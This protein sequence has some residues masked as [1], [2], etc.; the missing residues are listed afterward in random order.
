MKN[1]VK[2]A[3][4]TSVCIMFFLCVFI[5]CSY[6]DTAENNAAITAAMEELKAFFPHGKYWNGGKT[7]DQMIAIA[8]DTSSWS[9]S[10]FGVTGKGCGSTCTSNHY[11][12][13]DSSQCYAFARYLGYLMWPQFGFPGS[14]W[15]R[16]SG[17]D[18][19]S[20]TL[21]PGDIVCCGD[22]QHSA[23]V[24]K[25]S[26]TNAYFANVLGS[27]G[28]QIYW[29]EY[30]CGVSGKVTNMST[31]LQHVKNNGGYILKHPPTGPRLVP[32]PTPNATTLEFRNVVYPKTFKINTSIGWYLSGGTLVSNVNLSSIRSIIKDSNGNTISN[33]EGDTGEISIS[34]ESYAVNSIDSKVK[35]N[36]ITSSGNYTWTLIGKDS[37]GRTLTLVMPF[38]AVTSGTT[39]TSTMSIQYNDAVTATGIILGTTI[40]NFA[41]QT[42]TY[43]GYDENDPTFKLW[44]NFTPANTT[45]CNI[46]WTSSNENVLK[47]S[48][49]NVSEGVCVGTF[50][51]KGLGSTVITAK[52]QDGSNLQA[53]CT[54]KFCLSDINLTPA[55]KQVYINETTAI[56]AA[57]SPSIGKNS[58]LIWTSSNPTIATV[59]SNGVVTGISLGTTT[60]TAKAK[61][62]GTYNEIKDTCTITVISNISNLSAAMWQSP[63]PEDDALWDLPVRS[64]RVGEVF[65]L[66]VYWDNATFSNTSNLEYQF[67][68]DSN[69]GLTKVSGYDAS[70]KATQTGN[71]S[72]YF[73]IF[74]NGYLAS[75]LTIPITVISEDSITVGTQ[76]TR[77][78]NIAG[79][80]ANMAFIPDETCNYSFVLSS[81]AVHTIYDSNWKFVSGA[82]KCQLTAG[83][84]YYLSAGLSS[85]SETGSFTVRVDK[86][87]VSGSCGD[88]ASWLYSNGTLT[89]SGTGPMYDFARDAARPWESYTTNITTLVVDDGIT[90][91]GSNAFSYSCLSNIQ[92]AGSVKTIGYR[93]FLGNGAL[94]SI[95]LPE[96]LETIE[97][98]AFAA[99]PKLKTVSFPNSL[100]A[101]GSMSFQNAALESVTIPA[102]VISISG[103][104]FCCCNS[105]ATIKLQSGSTSFVL[106]DG[107]LYT[108]DGKRLV[109]YP[110][111]DARTTYMVVSGTEIIDAYAFYGA[112]NLTEVIMP[113]GVS[114]IGVYTFY[115]N[116]I[117]QRINLPLSLSNIGSNAFGECENLALGCLDGST[118]LEYAQENGITYEIIGGAC[119]D[120]LF[121]R[122]DDTT[123]SIFGSGAMND[124]ERGEQP[125]L[126]KIKSVTDIAMLGGTSIG[127]HAFDND[128]SKTYFTSI[129][130]PETLTSIGEYAFYNNRGLT[131][132]VLPNSV[133]DIANNAFR[134]CG[135]LKTIQLPSCL[136]IINNSTF[137]GCVILESIVIP[138]GVTYL[139]SYAFG[140][141]Y[142]L[143]SVSLPSTLLSLS[144]DVFNGCTMLTT[145]ELPDALYCIGREAFKDC[146]SLTSLHISENVT[147]FGNEPFS[148]CSNLTITC[149][150]GTTAHLYAKTNAIPYTLLDTAF[151][152]VDFTVPAGTKTIENEAFAGIGTRRVK[153]P[154]GCEQIGSHAFAACPN[155]VAIYIPED[156]TNI[157]TDAFYDV[158][159]LTIFGVD[160]SYAEFYAGKHGFDFVAV[161]K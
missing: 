120:D 148:G 140:A 113:E 5:N 161:D 83:Q 108:A 123:L 56:S 154:E 117:I 103:N 135:A 95:D 133:N 80:R 4:V 48:S 81:N 44:V 52:T 2:F 77:S 160:G 73:K 59:D 45:N 24:W 3:I 67:S 69:S 43:H 97:V 131:S 151:T 61:D 137:Y 106:N 54:I 28:C 50:T 22:R 86:E 57:M 155:L 8:N 68:T 63:Y 64:I 147:L 58:D 134:M 42:V 47:F 25:V 119:G 70:F 9:Q 10:S 156:C 16:K 40:E 65:T 20:V 127:N 149:F 90:R 143:S 33:G 129:T 60:I 11:P 101:I 12:D 115:R 111:A 21:E 29:G 104:P 99:C 32:T 7:V 89:I 35:F 92:L 152:N 102:G 87:I 30:Y 84:K 139:D 96:G 15:N 128:Q 93:A 112:H 51:I 55:S 74:E 141:C 46:T 13:K 153:L 1:I 39:S 6:A 136:E 145:I 72:V 94:V 159:F 37:N 49:A 158:N 114:S 105:L 109:A 110:L 41:G 142:Q 157:A 66:N 125:W 78:I 138:E 36:K 132:L 76:V 116:N 91:V 126:D 79:H 38:T 19:L 146:S 75:S 27:V 118:S 144:H 23:I 98:D 122:I 17:N 82:H 130:L 31:V 100:K 107:V 34:G 121:W 26:G 71:Y 62:P 18:V 88:N 14:A 53:S 124:Y 85:D 150:A